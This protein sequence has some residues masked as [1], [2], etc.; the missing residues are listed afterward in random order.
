MQQRCPIL[1]DM[2]LDALITRTKRYW[3]FGN[4]QETIL[5]AAM[6]P[7]YMEIGHSE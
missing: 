7:S 3:I 6:D 1:T 2:P 4:Q 5:S